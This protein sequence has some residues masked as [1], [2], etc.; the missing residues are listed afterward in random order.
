MLFS[1]AINKVR[2]TFLIEYIHKQIIIHILGQIAMNYHKS[3]TPL[4]LREYG[5]NIQLMAEIMMQETDP[6]K[7]ERM[8]HEII[9]IMA[10]LVPATREMAEYKKKLWDHLNRLVDY[11]IDIPTPFPLSPP[12]QS[13]EYQRISYNNHTTRFKQYGR[14]IEIMVEKISEIEDRAQQAR[15]VLQL[16]VI[17]KQI[18]QQYGHSIPNEQTM[19]EQIFEMSGNKLHF[20]LEELQPYAAASRS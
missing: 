14:N 12:L 1:K 3:N 9:R 19:L 7:K 11:Q 2:Y 4:R 5:R 15:L 13:R 8:A 18:L 17:M 10:T 16:L 6:Q 20:T